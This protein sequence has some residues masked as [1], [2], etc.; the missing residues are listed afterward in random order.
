MTDELFDSIDAMDSD[1]FASF[2]S[3]DCRFQF[4]N[5]PE[6]TGVQN[7]KAFVAGFFDSIES[8]SHTIV[9][10]WNIP[11]GAVFHGRVT[12]TRKDGSILTIPF[13]NILKMNSS[14]ITEYMIFADTSQLH[15]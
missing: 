6:V 7:I 5:M 2:L 9:N 3:K 8:L 10:S 11:G 12:Y 15:Q 14:G 13:A 1:L 4:G